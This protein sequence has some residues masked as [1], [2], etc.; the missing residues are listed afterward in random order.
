VR[1]S[2]WPAVAVPS[3]V[4]NSAVLVG[5]SLG[6]V[7]TATKWETLMTNGCPFGSGRFGVITSSPSSRVQLAVRPLTETAP[8]LSPAKSRLKR[9][10]DCVARAKIVTVPSMLWLGSLVS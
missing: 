8:T 4:V 5:S 7:G 10:S 9:E 3:G 1:E 2:G 6:S